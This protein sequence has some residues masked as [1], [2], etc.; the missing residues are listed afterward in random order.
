[1]KRSNNQLFRNYAPGLA[2]RELARDDEAE[3]GNVFLIEQMQPT[4]EM[5]KGVVDSYSFKEFLENLFFFFNFEKIQIIILKK[6]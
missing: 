5:V 3:E 2:P 6:I 4:D 1:M